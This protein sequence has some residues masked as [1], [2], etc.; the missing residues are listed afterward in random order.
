MHLA[1]MK[2]LTRVRRRSVRRRTIRRRAR[3]SGRTCA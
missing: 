2:T 3:D 1:A